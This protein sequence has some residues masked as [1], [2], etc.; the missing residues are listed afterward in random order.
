ML[1]TSGVWMAVVSCEV[2]LSSAVEL[3]IE[4]G[5]A[6]TVLPVKACI[7]RP[8]VLTTVEVGQ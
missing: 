8:S 4:E 6:T 5:A 1:V 3:G 2:T 7:L